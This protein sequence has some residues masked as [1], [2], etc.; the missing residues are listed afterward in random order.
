MLY[1]GINFNIRGELCQEYQESI[2]QCLFF[3]YRKS[4][5]ISYRMMA[6]NLEVSGE[7][8]RKLIKEQWKVKE[9]A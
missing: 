4:Q 1:R 2:W 5:N 3:L 7:K 9:D 6:E 8:L